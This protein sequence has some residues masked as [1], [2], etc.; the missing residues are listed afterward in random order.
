MEFFSRLDWEPV[1]HKVEQA[2]V[3]VGCDDAELGGKQ[4]SKIG[5]LTWVCFKDRLCAT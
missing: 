4:E 3:D 5:V 2:I 1:C